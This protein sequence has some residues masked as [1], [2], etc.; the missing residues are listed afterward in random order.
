MKDV[1]LDETLFKS[2]CEGKLQTTK[3]YED[4][5]FN[6]S[7]H[8][9]CV[10]TANTMPNIKIDSGVVRRF[11]GY[12]HKSKFTLN[13]NEV[14]EK[15][16][17]Y[18]VD[19][20]FVNDVK[21]MNLLNAWFD[22]LSEYCLK[23]I[24]GTVPIY[25]ENFNET[26]NIVMDSNDIY[27]DFVDSKL[28]VTNNPSHKIGKNQMHD[29]FSQMYPKKFMTP[30]QVITSL[31]EKKIIYDS[32]VRCD[33]IKGCFIGVKLILQMDEDEVKEF[34]D[35][36]MFKPNSTEQKLIKSLQDEINILKKQLEEKQI[37]PKPKELNIDN[38]CF[39]H[40][41]P[42]TIFP[43]VSEIEEIEYSKVYPSSVSSLTQ[44]EH[45]EGVDSD[46]ENEINDFNE[47]CDDDDDDDNNEST[48]VLDIGGDY[49][50]P[51]LQNI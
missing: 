15:N 29:L 6:F 47:D 50:D 12:T 44:N 7:H 9:K 22:I 30:L 39:L 17:I 8:G 37:K 51:I 46:S 13:K 40:N 27:Q 25:T 41:S 4:G 35:I 38:I 2:F 21:K 14:D 49:E 48:Y 10:T 36:N 45:Y 23:W 16:N 33:G 18:L 28:N 19:K 32:Q 43:T 26:K 3:L 20:E 24:N 11:L 34:N 42:K 1:K 31:K 5:Q